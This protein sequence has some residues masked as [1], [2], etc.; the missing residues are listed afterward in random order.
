MG[1][2]ATLLFPPHVLR[3]HRMWLSLYFQIDGEYLSTLILMP[4]SPFIL[5]DK[6]ACRGFELTLAPPRAHAQHKGP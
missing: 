2:T 6:V 5:K 1:T 3:I 4:P